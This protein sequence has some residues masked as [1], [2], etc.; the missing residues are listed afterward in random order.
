[1]VLRREARLTWREI[2]DGGIARQEPHDGAALEVIGERVLDRAADDALG[3]D[4]ARHLVEA[5]A[6][7]VG[8]FTL[9]QRPQQVLATREIF[10]DERF[11]DVRGGGDLL[12]RDA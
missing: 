5:A 3:R 8:E 11:G 7:Q 2:G 6:A 10:V 1:V 4:V 9:E 12:Q